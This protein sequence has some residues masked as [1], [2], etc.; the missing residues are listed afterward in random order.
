MPDFTVERYHDALQRLDGLYPRERCL[1]GALDQDP[2]RGETGSLPLNGTQE[3]GRRGGGVE[4]KRDIYTALD[5]NTLGYESPDVFDAR[6][7]V[8]S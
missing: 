1:C 4:V 2:H 5:F 6:V 3:C 8:N 7:R